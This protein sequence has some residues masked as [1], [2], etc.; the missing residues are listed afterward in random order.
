[1][2]EGREAAHTGHIMEPVP[3]VA[4]WNLVLLEDSGLRVE[5]VPQS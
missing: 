4:R 1:M 3:T 2:R 5:H